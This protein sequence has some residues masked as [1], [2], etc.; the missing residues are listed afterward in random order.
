MKSLKTDWWLNGLVF[1]LIAMGMVSLASIDP[2]LFWRQ[3]VWVI[4]AIVLILGLPLLNLRA[5]FS[6]RWVILSI[7]FVTILLLIATYFFAPMIAGTKSWLAI[8]SF[9]LQASEFMKAALIILFSAFFANRHVAIARLGTIAI[10]FV[11]FLIPA[12]LILIQ[13]DLGTA[14]VIF[15]IWFGYLLVSEIPLRY[16]FTFFMIFILAGV[17]SWN[18]GLEGYQKERVI[19]LFNPSYDPLGINYNVIQSKIAIGSAGFFGKGFMQGTQLQSGF[20][21]AASTDFIFASFVEEWGIL[22]GMVLIFTFLLLIYRILIIGIKSDN[23]FYRFIALGTAIMLLI[24][25]AINLG[26]NLGL[27]PVIG[28]SLPLVSY[29][30]SNLL[31]VAVL[32]GILQNIAE[33]RAGF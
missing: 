31:T 2:V 9:R 20:L 1:F 18:F 10:S 4:L 24:H 3:V 14:L 29:G 5:I 8:G 6:Y 32:V 19:A 28:V 33:K 16:L 23:N 30:G 26:S 17:L 21:P 25:F 13:P 15:G 11:Y 27:L 12:V 7:Y 22:G